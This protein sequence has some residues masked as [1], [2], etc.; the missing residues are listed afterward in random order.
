MIYESSNEDR[1]LRVNSDLRERR[2]NESGKN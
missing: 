2:Q 1:S